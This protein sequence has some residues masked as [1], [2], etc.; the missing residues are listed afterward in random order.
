[1]W[2]NL[3]S[4]ITTYSTPLEIDPQTAKLKKNFWYNMACTESGPAYNGK[5]TVDN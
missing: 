1:M 2:G 3:Y 4:K 5:C